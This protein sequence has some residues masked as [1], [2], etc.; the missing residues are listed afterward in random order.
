MAG[1]VEMRGAFRMVEGAKELL[2]EAQTWGIWNWASD[3]NQDRV[4]SAIECATAELAREVA[5]SKR[6]WSEGRKARLDLRRLRGKLADAED[7]LERATLQSKS[8]FAE[9]ER[10][11]DPGKARQG[12]AEAVRAIEIHERVLELAREFASGVAMR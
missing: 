9:A 12:A 11:L 6:S 8:I 1:T 2:R 5:K 7:E 3:A 10:E 4:R